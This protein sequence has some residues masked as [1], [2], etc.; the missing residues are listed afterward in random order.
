MEWLSNDQNPTCENCR[1]AYDGN[2]PCEECNKPKLL[3]QNQKAW[4]AWNVLSIH[5]RPSGWDIEC[6][7]SQAILHY[8]ELYDLSVQDFEKILFIDERMISKQI[9]KSDSKVKFRPK[10]R[11]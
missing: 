6:I 1:Y 7:P 11:R 9:E 8:C 4:M 2:P 10:K 5:D 3:P